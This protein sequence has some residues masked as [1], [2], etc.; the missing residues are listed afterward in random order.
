MSNKISLGAVLTAALQ[1]DALNEIVNFEM[2]D[3]VGDITVHQLRISPS[4]NVEQILLTYDGCEYSIMVEKWADALP[5]EGH[6][7]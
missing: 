5:P 3:L 1:A 4:L 2:P 6:R 7:P